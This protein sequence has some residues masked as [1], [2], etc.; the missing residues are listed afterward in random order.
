MYVFVTVT[1][2]SDDFL[3]VQV[4]V[5]FGICMCACACARN[6]RHAVHPGHHWWV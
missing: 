5:N 3:H 6:F 1:C 2:I 4:P